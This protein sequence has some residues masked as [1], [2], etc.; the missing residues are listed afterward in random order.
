MRAIIV[1]AK[2]Y[3]GTEPFDGFCRYYY[4]T[5]DQDLTQAEL[6][7]VDLPLYGYRGTPATDVQRSL[8]NACIAHRFF[9]VYQLSVDLHSFLDGKVVDI[10]PSSE[11][12][13]QQLKEYALKARDIEAENNARS[14]RFT[15]RTFT[16]P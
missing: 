1:Y 9:A 6:A 10:Q 12:L 8:T 2:T 3:R 11:A 14:A 13:Q 15:E 4:V 7:Y 5:G 16:F